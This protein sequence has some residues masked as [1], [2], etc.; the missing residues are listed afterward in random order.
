MCDAI[1]M[2]EDYT[3]LICKSFK[4]SYV[5]IYVCVFYLTVPTAP[6]SLMIVNITNSTVSLSWMSPEMPNGIITQYQLQYRRSDSS[7]NSIFASMSISKDNLTYTMTKLTS[8]TEYV[9]RVRAFTVVGHGPHSNTV[10]N[11]TSKLI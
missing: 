11:Y 7:N 3:I 1:H 2:H 10:T 6:R 4:S 5:R 8:N 9:F